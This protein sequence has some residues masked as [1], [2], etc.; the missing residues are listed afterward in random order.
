MN[1][2]AQGSQEGAASLLGALAQKHDGS[3]LDA[4]DLLGSVDSG[5]GLGDLLGGLL[6]GGS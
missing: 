2:S 3:L 5:G 6:G 4:D 1:A